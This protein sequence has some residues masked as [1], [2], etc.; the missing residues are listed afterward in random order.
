[1]INEYI[2]LLHLDSNATSRLEGRLTT[3][4]AFGEDFEAIKTHYQSLTKQS[5]NNKGER[6]YADNTI[7]NIIKEY[8]KYINWKKGEKQMTFENK[9]NAQEQ[10]QIIETQTVEEPDYTEYDDYAPVKKRGRPFS[11]KRT[12]K[13]TLYMT[14]D[15]MKKVSMLAN[16][17]DVSMI[18]LINSI[19][20]HYL[21]TRQDDINFMLNLEKQKQE[22][23]KARS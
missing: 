22:R 10:S 20:E 21:P 5:G 13:I 11:S 16:Y 1:M 7:D 15:T 9:L 19:V 8:K 18:D 14:S 2:A 4:E 23:K 17:D 3:C 12:D 6:R